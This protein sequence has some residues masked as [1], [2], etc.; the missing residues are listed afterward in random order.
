MMQHFVLPPLIPNL[1][2]R[3]S[4]YQ[5]FAIQH[6]TFNIQ[7]PYQTATVKMTQAKGVL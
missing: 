2:F 6:S 5:V 7:N 4:H 1:A 3:I